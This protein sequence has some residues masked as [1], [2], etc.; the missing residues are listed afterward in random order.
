MV[1]IQVIKAKAEMV[2]ARGV[3]NAMSPI[4]LPIYV[5]NTTERTK[6]TK[7]LIVPINKP[8]HTIRLLPTAR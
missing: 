6:A 7:I 2:S 4:T 5:D 8:S 1:T 3:L